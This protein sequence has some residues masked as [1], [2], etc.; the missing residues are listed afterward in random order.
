MAWPGEARQGVARLGLAWLGRARQAMKLRPDQ[1]E[2][3][4]RLREACSKHRRIILCAP[5][6]SGKTVIACELIRRAIE[7]GRHVLFLA[8]ARELV[9][10]AR[11]RLGSFGVDAGVI[12]AGTK[13]RPFAQVHVAS[14]DTLISRTRRQWMD[15]PP[16]DLVIADEAHRSTAPTWA[17]CFDQYSTTGHL[18]GLTATPARPS[19]VGKGLGDLYETIVSGPSYAELR[20]L[21]VIVPT[22]VFSHAPDLSSVPVRAGDYVSTELQRTMNRKRLVGDIVAHWMRFAHDRQTVAF[23]TGIAHSKAL[24]DEFHAHGVRVEH[25]DGTTHVDVRDEILLRL[26]HRDIQIVTNCQVLTEGWDC[27]IVS[28]TI[29][30]HPT[31]SIVRYRQMTS[32]A[33]RSHSEKDD[34]ILLDHAGGVNEH[35]F[36]D[37]DIEWDLATTNASEDAQRDRASLPTEMSECTD[38]GRVFQG[39]GLCP[40]CRTTGVVIPKP[41][42]VQPGTLEEIQRR[43]RR[44]RPNEDPRRKSWKKF[45]YI[46]AHTGRKVSAASAMFKRLHGEWPSSEIGTVPKPHERQ[47]LAR[48]FIESKF[49]RRRRS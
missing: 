24:A 12:M 3:I 30:A 26:R 2:T 33:N 16:A 15:F 48:D 9:T 43:P 44:R 7:R 49:G 13:Y 25:I 34:A 10:Q 45:L 18:I 1:Q 23:T 4:A 36:P 35:G 47:M 22:R 39:S 8:H 27:P 19:G 42:V 28:C 38:C 20:E 5:T 14:K 40:E 41:I 6:G 11:D 46:A 32:R 37:S 31:K 17:E 21:G 29:N